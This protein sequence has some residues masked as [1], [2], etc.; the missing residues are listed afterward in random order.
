MKKA[1]VGELVKKHTGDDAIATDDTGSI[2]EMML[3]L[4]MLSLWRYWDWTMPPM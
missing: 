1:S 3:R 4:A 2:L